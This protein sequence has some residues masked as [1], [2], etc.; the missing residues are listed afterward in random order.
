MC[1]GPTDA[2]AQQFNFSSTSF[3]STKLQQLKYCQALQWQALVDLYT[4]TKGPQWDYTGDIQFLND[5]LDIQVFLNEGITSFVPSF[6]QPA[7]FQVRSVHIGHVFTLL[8]LQRFAAC[9]QA[10]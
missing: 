10:I 1:P 9:A 3:N 6:G 7:L 8:V 2:T 5:P 4:Q